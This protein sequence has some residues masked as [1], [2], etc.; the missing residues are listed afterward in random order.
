MK[1]WILSELAEKL[2]VTV[3]GDGGLCVE[4][5]STLQ[6]AQPGSIAFL[7]NPLYQA[8][9][10]ETQATAVIV[11]PEFAEQCA[12]QAVLVSDNPYLTY[13]KA[14][15]LF[16]AAPRLERSVHPSAVVA[17]DVTLGDGVAIGANAVIESGVV[18]GAGVEIGHGSI[19]GA[20]SV[21]G[22]QTRLRSNVT[23][24]HGVTIGKR[25]HIHSGVVLGADGF[26]FAPLDGGWFKIAQLGG[27]T[28]GDDVDIG[29]NTTIDRGAIDDTKIGNGVILDNQIQIAH[30]VEIGDFTAIAGCTGIAG[31]TKIGRYCTIAGAAGIAGHLEI[32]D[33]VHITM[34]SAITKSIT[35]PGSY[36]SGTA[37]SSTSEWRK[38]AARFRQLDVLAKS[39][40]RLER[41]FKD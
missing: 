24:Y 8:Q 13:A 7:A 27:V 11:A 40:R 25:C 15:R 41:K 17:D 18:L 3:K 32:C 35:K 9:L 31:S 2:G 39:I 4:R 1:Q 26:G 14:S 21:I 10:A 22:E 29:A 12:S 33:K 37:M 36:S 19:V 5:L 34:R 6:S 23:L 20:N 30:N 16:D 38:N 28:I